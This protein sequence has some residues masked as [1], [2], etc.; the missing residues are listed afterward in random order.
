MKRIPLPIGA[1]AG[2]DNK[3]TTDAI[4][5]LGANCIVYDAHYLD[6]LGNKK[7]VKLKECYPI[8]ANVTRNKNV[9]I[10]KDGSE[11]E[12]AYARFEQSYQIASQMQNSDTTRSTAVYSLDLF[13]YNNTKYVAMIPENGI[14]YDKD[15][16]EN[17]E[18]IIRTALALTNTVGRYHQIG[19]LHLDVK[20]SNFI[21]TADHTGKGKNIALFDFDTLIPIDNI[22]DK[23][24]H[25]V[26]Y[27]KGWAAPEQMQQQIGKLCPA[28]DLFSIGAVLFERVMRRQVENSD[29]SPFA[30]WEYDNR[31][32][33][34]SVNPKVKRLL[35]DIFH[36]TL[37][38]NVKKRYQSADELSTALKELLNVVAGGKPY[39]ISSFPVS[40]CHFVG[41]SDEIKEL[42]KAVTE[43]NKV[44]ITGCGGIGKSELAKQYKALY[45]DK[46]DATVFLRYTGSIAEALRSIAIKGIN[47]DKLNAIEEL[48][49]SR[50]LLVLDNFDVAPDEEVD[51]DRLL[52]LG[53]KTIITTR[54]DF[55][56]AYP[57]IPLIRIKEMARSELRII[58]ETE[59]S[60]TLSN[61]EYMKLMPIF[62]MGEQCTFYLVMLAK[63][64]K[65]GDYSLEELCDK[66]SSGL[67]ALDDTEDILNTKDG[68][69]IKQT[70]ARAMSELFKLTRLTPNQY[71]MLLIIYHLGCLNLSK[72]QIK[73]IA[74]IDNTV[75]VIKRM[76][77]LNELIERGFVDYNLWGSA[78]ALTI[79]DVIR[80]TL[81]YDLSPSVADSS[82]L[83]MFIERDFF[84]SKDYIIGID[85][86]DEISKDKVEYNF[87]CIFKIILNSYLVNRSTREYYVDLLYRMLGGEENAAD[88]IWN[89]YTQRI[90][91][92]FNIYSGDMHNDATSRVKAYIVLLTVFCYQT[93]GLCAPEDDDRIDSIKTAEKVFY[94][95]LKVI[96][97][98]SVESSPLIDDLCRPFVYCAVQSAERC[99]L[100]DPKLLEKI[101]ELH[102]MCINQN[103]TPF[104]SFGVRVFNNSNYEK[105]FLHQIKS[106]ANRMDDTAREEFIFRALGKIML[107]GLQVP[108]I[109]DHELYGLR[110]ELF[111]VCAER[112]ENI[113]EIDPLDFAPDPLGIPKH[114]TIGAGLLR[115]K[116]SISTDISEG[117][118]LNEENSD[119]K[120]CS[121]GNDF[122]TTDLHSIADAIQSI[123]S[124]EEL[125]NAIERFRCLVDSASYEGFSEEEKDCLYLASER[126]LDKFSDIKIIDDFPYYDGYFFSINAEDAKAILYS[127]NAVMFCL[128]KDNTKVHAFLKKVFEH[129]KEYICL[130][131]NEAIINFE[132]EE[133]CDL[134]FWGAVNRLNRL[135]NAGVVLPYLIDY[136]SMVEERLRTYSKFDKSWMY[137]YYKKIVSTATTAKETLM[138]LSEIPSSAEERLLWFIFRGDI[139]DEGEAL[140]IYD[141]IIAEYTLEIEKIAGSKYHP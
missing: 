105:L 76:N 137:S 114:M 18:D 89:E 14:S 103:D 69:R 4:I 41:R 26:S 90:A 125:Y 30:E 42:H 96:R 100:I 16:S 112:F 122:I 27:S 53:C 93:R 86:D 131:S 119:W 79:S 62:R 109:I 17:I 83:K 61:E 47:I 6:S 46:Y 124:A 22:T 77:A 99:K 28:T 140:E 130:I 5:G 128:L 2:I 123:D 73:E 91:H 58:F 101:F 32:D 120:L 74:T 34:K 33:V 80:D 70:V 88:Y 24:I 135:S 63:L 133:E 52:S 113:E 36:K 66:V 29:M 64:L 104:K 108:F 72:K 117:I 65:S 1:M 136:T 116:A 50:T 138:Q 8:A 59:S 118:D 57:N 21:A 85:I 107:N 40:T 19:Y 141:D 81:E 45:A 3:Y 95:A 25:S 92:F 44:F 67:S 51:L 9:L 56:D 54:T 87:R 13:E 11:K 132:H 98:N 111:S 139:P 31:F 97:Q 115:F 82:I 15:T 43:A 38:S 129:S 78:D 68:I 55:S 7:P 39:I 134:S 94:N 23:L 84:V 35:T 110:K 75:P 48:C 49:D 126:L 12:S 121:S 71:E 60:R 127:I 102:P 106:Q 37:A 20:P 10:W